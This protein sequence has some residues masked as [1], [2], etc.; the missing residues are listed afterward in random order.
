MS[1]LAAST[2]KP[3]ARGVL[4]LLMGRR[5]ALIVDWRYQRRVAGIATA[6]VGA[7]CLAL[8]GSLHVEIAAVRR[9]V[10][11]DPV[12]HRALDAG[13]AL[14][15][16]AL[17]SAGL[18]LC[19]CVFVMMLVE[20]HRTAGAAFALK[21]ALAAMAE[22]RYGTRAELRRGDQLRDLKA[23]IDE[24]GRSLT[25]RAE[26]DAQA[27][28]VLAERLDE[29]KAEEMGA[30]ASEVRTLAQRTRLRLEA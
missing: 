17:V 18:V 3:R 19:A 25:R 10:A 2:E 6:L 13:L 27:L 14:P 29:A 11:S 12:L 1:D 22:G 30:L 7:G 8:A 28:D 21:R 5:R 4:G 24:L 20:T 16:L 26:L 9:A 23:S 15:T